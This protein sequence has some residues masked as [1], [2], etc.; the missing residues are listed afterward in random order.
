VPV[1]RYTFGEKGCREMV[2]PVGLSHTLLAS[3]GSRLLQGVSHWRVF[4]NLYERGVSI[5]RSLASQV[6]CR[7]S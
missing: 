1:L 7:L 4:E 3:C 2:F 6:I 5:E